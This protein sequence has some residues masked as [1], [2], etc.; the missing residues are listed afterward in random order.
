MIKKHPLDTLTK[1]LNEYRNNIK[2]KICAPRYSVGSSLSAAR[3]E[4][5]QAL[6]TDDDI[7]VSMHRIFQGEKCF[8]QVIHNCKRVNEI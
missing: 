5:M 1:R 3:L 6:S 4:E 7:L 2:L 8:V